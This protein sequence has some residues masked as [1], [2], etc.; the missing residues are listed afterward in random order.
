[1]AELNAKQLLDLVNSR[2]VA[3]GNERARHHGAYRRRPV[4][5]HRRVQRL[6]RRVLGRGQ[7][8]DAPW[9]CRHD[10]PHYRRSRLR[11]P[12][13]YPR[14]R[15]RPRR[16]PLPGTPARSKAR[17]TLPARRCTNA[18][19]V[20]MPATRTAARPS[21][22]KA[23]AGH[24]WPPCAACHGRCLAL[25]RLRPLLHF[26]PSQPAYNLRR[27]IEADEQGR[28]RFRSFLPPGYAIPPNSPVSELFEKLGRH[29]N[30]PAHI[31]FLI[32][33]GTSGP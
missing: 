25:Q 22:W 17:S 9:P 27:R 28:Y 12:A 33:G 30:R 5:H 14:G 13:R 1:M 29:G 2:R 19:Y 3:D 6:A 21:S 18:R 31:H 26:D 20:L 11:P 24:G 23:G 4:S 15:D 10:R 7:V 16:Q 32:S 8:A